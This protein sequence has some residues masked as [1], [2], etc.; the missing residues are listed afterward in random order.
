MSKP[1]PT[2]SDLL[3]HTHNMIGNLDF[4]LQKGITKDHARLLVWQTK[5]MLL[6]HEAQLREISNEEAK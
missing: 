5:E 2:I 1:K 3:V 6:N 4:A